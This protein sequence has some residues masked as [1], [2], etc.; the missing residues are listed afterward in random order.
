MLPADGRIVYR[1][2]RGY[3]PLPATAVWEFETDE[4]WGTCDQLISKQ[5][6]SDFTILSGPRGGL[7]SVSH[8][9]GGIQHLDICVVGQKP[10]RVRCSFVGAPD[11]SDQ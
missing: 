4:N 5:L 7:S 9:S 8:L 1:E 2:F 6:G 11:L 10:L 3:F